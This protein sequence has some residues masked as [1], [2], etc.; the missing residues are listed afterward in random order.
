MGQHLRRGL[1]ALASFILTFAVLPASALADGGNE[2][3]GGPPPCSRN[4]CRAQIQ[5]MCGPFP[6][7]SKQFSQCA[8]G[9]LD[10][11]D[12]GQ[13]SCVGGT[14]TTT[15]APVTTTTSTSSTTTTQGPATTT[16][17]TPATTTTTGAPVTTTTTTG[18]PTTTTTQPST[19]CCVQSSAGGAFDTCVLKPAGTCTGID[20]GPGTCSPNPCPPIGTTSTTTPPTTTT[21]TTAAVTTTTTSPATTTTTGAATTTTS[22]TTAPTTTTTAA[23]TT[24]TTVTSST[25]TTTGPSFTSLSFTTT[26]GTASCGSAGFGTPPSAPVSGELDSDTACTTKIN[27]LGLG[28]LYFG[29]GAATVVAGGRIPDGATSFLQITGSGTLGASAGTSPKNCTKG[30]GPGQHCV[31]NNSLPTCTSDANCGGAAGSCA[32]DANCFFGPPLPILSP[33]PF[34]ALTTCVINA[35]Q[36]DASGTFNGATGDS[37]VSLPL[38]SRVYISGNTASPCPKCL[39]GSCDPTWKTNT[40][41]TSPDTGTACTA[42]GI[43]MTSVDCRP[44]LGGFQAPLPVDLTP[45]TSGTASKTAADGLFCNPQTDAGAFGQAGAQCIQETG[46]PAGDLSDGQPHNSNLASIF[47]IPA[48]GNAAVDGVADLPGPGAIGLNGNAQLQ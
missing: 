18:A 38:S 25:T 39:S 2:S 8:K 26:V 9:V 41:T 21:S 47:C 14:T 1:V 16:T 46:M 32:L 23:P 5:A 3:G 20:V 7:G 34:A 11:C 31:N 37:T 42:T 28:C 48:T 44:A 30:A 22:T 19:Q 6:P 35:V 13:I 10:A 17:T 43:Q 45:L 24:T 12:S 4:S 27:D 33:P 36:T 15:G 29:G 40:G